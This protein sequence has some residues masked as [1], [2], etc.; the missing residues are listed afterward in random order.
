MYPSSFALVSSNLDAVW[1]SFT[2]SSRVTSFTSSILS[3]ASESCSSRALTLTPRTASS[4]A[5]SAFTAS[6]KAMDSATFA[7]SVA[8]SIDPSISSMC[9]L[10]ISSMTGCST[11]SGS[12][13]ALSSWFSLVRPASCILFIASSAAASAAS[14]AAFCAISSAISVDI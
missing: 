8:S 11:V 5:N 6:I 1:A 10:M 4:M 2:L 14:F 9:C 7:S 3:V 12:V 13:A